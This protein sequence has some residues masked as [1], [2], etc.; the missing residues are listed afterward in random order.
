MLF[1]I[2]H[3]H[4]FLSPT[5]PT[6]GANYSTLSTVSRLAQQLRFMS[7][8]NTLHYAV[9]TAPPEPIAPGGPPGFTI[10]EGAHWSPTTVTLLYGAKEAILIDALT[11]VSQAELLADWIEATAP[12][13]RLTTIYV[14]HGHA[15]HWF[16]AAPLLKRFPGASFVA[17]PGTVEVMKRNV[18]RIPM[19]WGRWFPGDKIQHGDIIAESLG[20]KR[21][22]EIE[23][24]D[25]EIFDAGFT[26]TDETTYV[27]V[28][29]IRLVVAGDIVYNG[30]HQHLSE[31]FRASQLETW[32]A[33]L[34][35]IESLEPVAVV[36]GHKK[37]GND[38]GPENIQTSIDYIET[39]EALAGR[40]QSSKELLALMQEKFGDRLNP[41]MLDF[42]CDA[43]FTG[44]K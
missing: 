21:H 7:G 4:A 17:T 1:D 36:A 10:P 33:A 18:E 28:P 27:W 3:L 29:S 2:Y 34:K 15:D 6:R 39:F 13:R 38:D 16:G 24:H 31:G 14:T 8:T 26:D 41:M 5:D 20:E 42:A 25:V 32:K 35:A 37:P 22:L 44:D 9:Y 19:L 40:A 23:G 43:V 30:V 11:L 12:G